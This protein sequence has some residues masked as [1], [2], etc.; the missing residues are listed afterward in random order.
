MCLVM[1]NCLQ[2]HGLWP[3]GSTVHGILQART[4]EWVAIFY[5]RGSSWSRPSDPWVSNPCLLHWQAD[6]LPLSHLGDNNNIDLIGIVRFNLVEAHK[7][8]IISSICKSL[9]GSFVPVAGRL[10]G[11]TSFYC[12]LHTL[13][14]FTKWSFVTTLHCQI[15]VS[16]FSSK[17]LIKVY[18]SFL[19]M[20]C[21]C[22]LSGLLYVV[23]ITF[24]CTEKPQNW[25]ELLYSDIHFIGVVWKQTYNISEVY[26][27]WIPLGL[28]VGN[29]SRKTLFAL[30]TALSSGPRIFYT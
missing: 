17:V 18:T 20:Q 29:G 3:P 27:C 12:T 7:G 8:F 26:L 22:T 4:L 13:C 30:F 28:W 19:Y 6:S 5:S 16:I 23:N 11:H 10:Y 15:M 2:P 14:L 9:Q 21:Y 24:I 25:C 1:W